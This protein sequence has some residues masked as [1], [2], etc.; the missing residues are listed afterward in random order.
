M[1][2]NKIDMSDNSLQNTIFDGEYGIE[3]ESLRVTPDLKLSQT[4][5][6]FGGNEHISRDFCENQVELITD[7][8]TSIDG[9]LDQLRSLHEEVFIKLRKD[10]ELLWYFSNPP[11]V[12]SEDEIP[13]AM[14]DSEKYNYRSYLSQKYGKAKM[15]YSG[16]HLNFS[17]PE[18]TIAAMYERSDYTDPF[19]FKNAL[20][21]SLAAKLVKYSWL[22]V[23]LTA[24]SPLADDSF[25]SMLGVPEG[26]RKSYASFRCSEHGYWNSFTPVF[27]FSNLERY[28]N[29]IKDMIDSGKIVSC[30]ELYYPIRLKCGSRYTLEDLLSKGISHI[31]LRMLDVNPLSDIGIFREDI[32]FIHILILYLLSQDSEV[33]TENDQV[34]A[35]SNMKNAALYNDTAAKISDVPLK[36]AA[37]EELQRIAQFTK[38]YFPQYDNIINYQINNISK[39][40]RYA[41][42]INST[43]KNNYL[44]GGAA[45]SAKYRG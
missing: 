4:L 37:L 26:S 23:Y 24:A 1:L 5:H 29:S 36:D 22:I 25:L 30:S 40:K 31:E 16:I 3:K 34:Q 11:K 17:F 10:N 2:F 33:F 43:L 19:H 8:F 7:V 35:I 44:K 14:I 42:L 9:A 27:D 21:I 15:L 39:G 13:I 38:Q 28:V 6:N 32:E 20:Y 45:L 12:D 41:E 18:K